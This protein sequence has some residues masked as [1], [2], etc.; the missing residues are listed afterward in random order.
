MLDAFDCIS[1][2]RAHE[3]SEH[4]KTD[5][6]HFNWAAHMVTFPG[7]VGE[8]ESEIGE[9]QKRL[10]ST[11]FVQLHGNIIKPTKKPHKMQQDKRCPA[12]T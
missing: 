7:C 8:A 6:G 11:I 5:G 2:P 4:G 10:T 12:Q 9:T 3:H 1:G